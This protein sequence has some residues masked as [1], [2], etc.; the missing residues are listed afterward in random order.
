MKNQHI[1]VMI[2]RRVAR[3]LSIIATLFVLFYVQLGIGLLYN[4]ITFILDARFFLPVILGILALA[5][6]IISW[7]KERLG[8]ILFIITFLLVIIFPF[9]FSLIE[10]QPLRGSFFEYIFLG[11]IG[12][13]DPFFALR[14]SPLV[15][16]ILFLI[17]S[18]L[19][20]K[21]QIEA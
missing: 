14:Y 20:S 9:I 1:S 19:S 3:V 7:W 16:G 8:G 15:V 17:S 2:I 11:F 6:F 21:T 5:A 12:H 18:S 13:F 4:D 10:H